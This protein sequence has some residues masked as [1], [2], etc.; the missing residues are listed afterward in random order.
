MI[1]DRN[2]L[3]FPDSFSILTRGFELSDSPKM[4]NFR[5]D[6]PDSFSTL[7]RE[8]GFSGRP[9]GRLPK[10]RFARIRRERNLSVLG[11]RNANRTKLLPFPII[12][13]AGAT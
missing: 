10:P 11:I 8:G 2:L 4:G 7:T 3:D 5:L 12:F 1:N 6:I 13:R 9:V